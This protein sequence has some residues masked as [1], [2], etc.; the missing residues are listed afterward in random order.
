M[1]G[2]PLRFGRPGGYRF[3]ITDHQIVRRQ[4]QIANIPKELSDF[5]LFGGLPGLNAALF[6]DIGQAF[7]GAEIA[8]TLHIKIIGFRATGEYPINL[9]VGISKGVSH[10]SGAGNVTITGTLNTV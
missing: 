5:Q 6:R 7:K 2:T 4:I 1:E 8:E 3:K 9:N 10:G